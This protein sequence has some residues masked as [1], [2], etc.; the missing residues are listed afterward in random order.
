MDGDWVALFFL[1]LL[2]L[3]VGQGIAG[4]QVGHAVAGGQVP[5]DGLVLRAFLS[6][7]QS[8]PAFFSI[9]SA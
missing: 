9:L 3:R 7:L 8:T 5:A 4:G 6:S 2:G 1:F